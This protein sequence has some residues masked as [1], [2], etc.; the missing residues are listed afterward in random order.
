MKIILF[1][2]PKHFLYG[3]VF[4]L[5][6]SEIGDGHWIWYSPERSFTIIRLHF[7]IE[8]DSCK[9]ISEEKFK[10]IKLFL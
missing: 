6:L 7:L 5:T 8:E 1:H 3:E 4:K 10:K 9:E 2:N